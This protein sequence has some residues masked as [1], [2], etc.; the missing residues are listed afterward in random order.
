MG[1]NVDPNILLINMIVALIHDISGSFRLMTRFAT[2]C[3]NGIQVWYTLIS[4]SND[5]MI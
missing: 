5:Q 3:L 1:I 4:K 2:L